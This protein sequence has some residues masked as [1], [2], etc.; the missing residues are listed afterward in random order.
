MFQTVKS[1]IHK[2]IISVRE[3]SYCEDSQRFL[4]QTSVKKSS[5]LYITEFCLSLHEELIGYESKG[6]SPL[7]KLASGTN[8]NLKHFFTKD[9]Q[10]LIDYYKKNL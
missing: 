6:R 8:L 3:K 7:L 5:P 2:K 10:G 9:I 1:L 4:T